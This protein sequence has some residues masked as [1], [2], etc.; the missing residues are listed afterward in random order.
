V[1]SEPLPWVTVRRNRNGKERHYWQRRGFKLVR[2]PED[3]VERLAR[4]TELNQTADAGA[5]GAHGTIA[6]CIA[7]YRA[8]AKFASPDG[9]AKSTRKVYSRWLGFYERAIGRRHVSAFTRGAVVELRELLLQKHKLGT[10]NHA[11]AV[12]RLVLEIARNRDLITVNPATDPELST[13]AARETVWTDD[14]FRAVADAASPEVRLAMHLLL[15]TAQRPGDVVKMAWSQYDAP[16]GRIMVRQEKTGK[17]MRELLGVPVHKALRAALEAAPRKGPLITV[18]PM[19]RAWTAASLRLHVHKAMKLAEVD[20]RAL[21][22][23]DLRRTAV[24]KLAE[25]GASV[26]QIAAV[27]GH[28]LKAVEKIL[29]V[30]LPRRSDVAAA[31]MA[32]WEKGG[33]R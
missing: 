22:N 12:L 31:G 32:A 15:Y 29:A 18:H 11:F 17:R 26:P 20:R 33:A 6:W 1:P 28:G 14:Q 30:Y 10:V 13:A 4:V 2:L 7:Q 24:V 3:P 21:Q 9:L 8:S 5:A 23:R 25:A 16:N 27:T 19:G